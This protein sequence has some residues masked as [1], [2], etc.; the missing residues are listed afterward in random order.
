MLRKSFTLIEMLVVVSIIAILATIVIVAVQRS[1]LNARDGR[2][3]ADVKSIQTALEQYANAHYGN[4]PLAP[5]FYFNGRAYDISETH[6]KACDSQSPPVGAV[7]VADALKP[8]LDP[9]PKDPILNPNETSAKGKYVYVSTTG[10]EYGIQ[11]YIE[12]TDSFCAVGPEGT[13]WTTP[14]DF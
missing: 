6:S 1:S 4:Y 9:I 13:G 7:R 10:R 8:Y 11:I 14:C 2:R 12:D 5:C 3:E